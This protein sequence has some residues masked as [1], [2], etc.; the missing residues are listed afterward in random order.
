[1]DEAP[2]F[3]L[4]NYEQTIFFKR[5]D[6]GASKTLLCSPIVHRD[7]RDELP[8]RASL[9][10]VLE[11]SVKAKPNKAQ[12][13]RSVVP[14]TGRGYPF[15]HTQPSA[16][17]SAQTEATAASGTPSLGGTRS[18]PRQPKLTAS[19][20]I[21]VLQAQ[22]H[23]MHAPAVRGH[24]WTGQATSDGCPLACE[25]VGGKHPHGRSND[26]AVPSGSSSPPHPFELSGLQEPASSADTAGTHSS[27]SQQHSST[28]P[29]QKH[30]VDS[31]ILHL[32]RLA[33]DSTFALTP[34]TPVNEGQHGF[35]R[36]VSILERRI[37]TSNK[38]RIGLFLR[39][40]LITTCSQPCDAP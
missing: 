16:P 13:A 26:G 8:L 25:N 30:Q 31:D 28:D 11:Q 9:L 22:A 1:M 20:P 6:F 40:Q 33:E 18:S 32:Q 5:S 37:V 3:G 24:T 19:S 27:L 29:A 23:G 21:T 7:G 38:L 39:L 4:S 14:P 17:A 12:L 35:C 10:F 2:I 15:K 34:D 36:Q